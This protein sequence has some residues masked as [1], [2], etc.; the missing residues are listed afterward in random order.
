LRGSAN[1]AGTLFAHIR[2]LV[3]GLAISCSAKQ[4][5]LIPVGENAS[6]LIIVAHLEGVYRSARAGI[7]RDGCM[8]VQIHGKGGDRE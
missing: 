1:Q 2:D 3:S 6:W 8:E 4:E 7:A 5:R